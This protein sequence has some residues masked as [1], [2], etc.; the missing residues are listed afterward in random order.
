M[1]TSAWTAAIILPNLRFKFVSDTVPHTSQELGTKPTISLCN[2]LSSHQIT[3]AHREA[4]HPSS[5]VLVGAP[6]GSSP[7]VRC[8]FVQGRFWGVLQSRPVHPAQEFA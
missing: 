1:P 5:E 4:V 3:P 6:M 7:F 8:L 2:Q